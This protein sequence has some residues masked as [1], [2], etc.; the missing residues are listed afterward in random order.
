MARTEKEIYL[1]G[2]HL[3]NSPRMLPSD[4][5]T[6]WKGAGSDQIKMFKCSHQLSN[7]AG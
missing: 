5:T 7:P 3:S 6:P 2:G 1:E 4:G